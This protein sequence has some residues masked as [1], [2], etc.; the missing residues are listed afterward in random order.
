MFE[1]AAKSKE[2]E[3]FIAENYCQLECVD[4]EPLFVC[5]VCDEGFDSKA[6]ITQHIEEKHESLMNDDTSE[7]V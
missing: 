3:V 6:E 5:Y 1:Y 4:G 7:G 2:S